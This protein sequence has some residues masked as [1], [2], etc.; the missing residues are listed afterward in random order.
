MGGG[1]AL[2][3]QCAL[4]SSG[5]KAQK[6]NKS[7]ENTNKERKK[8]KRGGSGGRKQRGTGEEEREIKRE[9]KES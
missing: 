7:F 3:P 2:W 9:V 1:N 5:G 8:Q 6:T 4:H